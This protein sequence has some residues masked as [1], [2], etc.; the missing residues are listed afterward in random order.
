[1]G[2]SLDVRLATSATTDAKTEVGSPERDVRPL[3]RTA[4]AARRVPI[5]TQ[6]G[7]TGLD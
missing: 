4:V 5:A 3:A 2:A 7:A 1:M 6:C